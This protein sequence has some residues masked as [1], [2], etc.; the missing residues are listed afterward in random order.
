MIGPINLVLPTTI[1]SAFL[2]LSSSSLARANVFVI[3]SQSHFIDRT[4]SDRQS[5]ER[6]LIVW[7]VGQGLWVTEH[8][9]K[10]CEHFDSG[11]EF[12]PWG[13][14]I[15]SCAAATL[16]NEFNYSHWDLDHVRVVRLAFQR[17]RGSCL[18]REPNG[19]TESKYK[20]NLFLNLP[21]CKHNDVYESQ[22][23]KSP[24]RELIEISWH[25]FSTTHRS[26][27]NDVS[28]VVTFDKRVL[29]PGDSTA[30]EE[31]AW[32]RSSS[33]S[34]IELLVAGHHGSR[35]STSEQLLHA[36]PHLRQAV[37]SARAARYGHP[38]AEVRSRLRR[39]GV[40]LISTED[41]GSLHFELGSASP[42]SE[43][44]SNI[45]SST[46]NH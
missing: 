3:K 9:T 35:T 4:T 40:A 28:R 38:H 19:H 18:E 30:R 21:L 10:G 29:V 8:N 1:V 25:K 15:A 17:L 2:C 7:N 23:R 20:L 34:S 11:G 22:E 31:A 45:L 46:E 13:S 27:S 41:W 32:S 44:N 24:D 33:L 14:I 16:Q 37:A 43:R 36:L 26:S 42:P 5:F 39:H 12:A 6:E